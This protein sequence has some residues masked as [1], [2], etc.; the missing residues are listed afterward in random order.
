MRVGISVTEVGPTT[1]AGAVN[2]GDTWGPD[3]KALALSPRIG[4]RP[5][6]VR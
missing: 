6:R 2:I 5:G 1:A 3:G 4:A